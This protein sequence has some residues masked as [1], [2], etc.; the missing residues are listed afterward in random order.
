MEYFNNYF[1]LQQQRKTLLTLRHERSKRKPHKRKI[2]AQT[3]V[4]LNMHN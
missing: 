3:A 2:N 4:V 1:P